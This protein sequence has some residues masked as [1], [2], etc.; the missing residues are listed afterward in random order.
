[1]SEITQIEALLRVFHAK[2]ALLRGYI[3]SATRD[4]HATEDILQEIAIGELQAQKQ[5]LDVYTVQ[6]RFALAAIY[7][8]AAAGG[9]AGE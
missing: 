3:F 2:R 8:L 4:Y 5:R 7:D 1:M 9:D 6:A